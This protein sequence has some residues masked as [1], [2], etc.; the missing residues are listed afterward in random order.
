[1]PLDPDWPPRLHDHIA[2]THG[3]PVAVERLAGMSLSAV[4]RVHVA[5]ASAIVKVSP[6]GDEARFYEQI[7]PSLR[8]AGVPIPELELA[9]HEPDSHWLVIE[10]I[11]P[12][13]QSFWRVVA[14]LLPEHFEATLVR[15][16]AG[17]MFV[18]RRSA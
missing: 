5:G 18:V 13:A 14:A 4:W 9:L 6:S 10:D 1:M 3:A 12:A 16:K 8:T 15:A 11:I 2:R 7:A 17:D